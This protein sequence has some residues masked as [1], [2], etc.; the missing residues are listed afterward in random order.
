M[1]E[2]KIEV[3]IISVDYIDLKPTLK[4]TVT[5]T[6][7]TATVDDRFITVEI[8]RKVED[9]TE[10]LEEILKEA[11][12]PRSPLEGKVFEVPK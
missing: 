10:L 7:V 12:K 11:E 4:T 2:E 1:A 3:T 8:P 5:H 6:L 9:E